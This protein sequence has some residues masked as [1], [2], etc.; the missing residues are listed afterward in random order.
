MKSSTLIRSMLSKEN[1]DVIENL[2]QGANEEIDK[3]SENNTPEE[4]YRPEENGEL[5]SSANKTKEID[6]LWRNFKNVQFS[7][8]SPAV[9]V[10]LGFIGGIV[11]T[12][13][14][15]GALGY[16]VSKTDIAS[17]IK[18]GVF[19]KFAQ[20]NVS[21]QTIED[22]VEASDNTNVN[23]PGEKE[24]TQNIDDNTVE[25]TQDA[26]ASIAGAKKHIVAEGET[27]EGIIKHYYGAY[28]PERA[29][30]IKQVNNLQTLDKIGIGQELIIP[31]VNE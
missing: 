6:M 31:G 18:T 15:V 4:Y 13:L 11:S 29:E 17:S 5:S 8:R 12:L 14:V 9:Y 20:N 22:K 1:M 23:I 3:S 21:E 19:S 7:N 2:A 30:K 26:P 28:T 27:V 25:Q 10:T 24:T 16:F